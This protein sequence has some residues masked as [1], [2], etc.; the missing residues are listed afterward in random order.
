MHEDPF[1][2]INYPQGSWRLATMLFAGGA[3][4]LVGVAV[5]ALAG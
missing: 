3:L 5:L 2:Q 4:M 1:P